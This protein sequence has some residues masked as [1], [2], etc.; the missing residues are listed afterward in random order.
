MAITA[1]LTEEKGS[2]FCSSLISLRK[3][4]LQFGDLESR[5][6]S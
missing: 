2:S 1:L 5:T 6:G 3:P 4:P